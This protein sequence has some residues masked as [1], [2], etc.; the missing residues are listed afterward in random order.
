MDIQTRVFVSI[1]ESIVVSGKDAGAGKRARKG[2][3]D[4]DLFPPLSL[5]SS[6]GTAPSDTRE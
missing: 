6:R 5:T 1:D 3:V 2:I 4:C